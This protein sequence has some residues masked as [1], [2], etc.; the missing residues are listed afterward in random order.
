M[1]NSSNLP[2]R[3]KKTLRILTTDRIIELNKAQKEVIV[4]NTKEPDL[5][6]SKEFKS[7]VEAQ[8]YFSIWKRW[9]AAPTKSARLL[10][11]VMELT[12]N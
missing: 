7:V 12:E 5:S 6:F 4:K 1:S 8:N 10:I 3:N 2:K 9:K 11:E